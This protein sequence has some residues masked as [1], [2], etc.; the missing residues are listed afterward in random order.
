MLVQEEFVNET[1]GNF[2][3]KNDPYEPF[4]DNVKKLFRSY[5]REYGR[6]TSKAY[7][8]ENGESKAIG[9]V[10]SKKMKSEDCK[11]F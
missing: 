9:W 11:N 4:T 7:I 8:D 1:Q 10:F 3:G 5:Q 2:I 6:C